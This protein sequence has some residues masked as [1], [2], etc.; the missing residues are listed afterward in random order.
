MNKKELKRLANKIAEAEFIIQTS[1]DQKEKTIAMNEIIALSN[2]IS[3]AEEI[4]T[5]DT[6]V[7]EK[8]KN[9]MNSLT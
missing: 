1:T 9:K 7:Q 3:S 6:M 2:K 8:L 4:D 5:L